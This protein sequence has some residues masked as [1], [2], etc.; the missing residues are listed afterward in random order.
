MNPTI[1]DKP[2]FWLSQLN[3]IPNSSL[4]EDISTEFL[5]IGGG[6]TGL[7]TAY[8]LK[9]LNPNSDITLIEKEYI[10]FGASGRNAGFCMS[11]FGLDLSLTALRYGK[12]NTLSA[13][14]YTKSGIKMVKNFI[15]ENQID[16]DFEYPGF[17]RVAT[18]K[19]YEKR[20]FKEYQF[21]LNI[22]IDD[23]KWLNKEEIKGYIYSPIIRCGW[24]EENCGLLN[25]AKLAIGM[26]NLIEKKGVKIYEKTPFVK[27]K[28]LNNGYEV[29]TEKGSIKTKKIV[30]ATNAY[31]HLI[32]YIKRKQV[33][34]F[35]HIV[36]TEPLT[37]NQI[38][39]IGWLKRQG[40]EDS[41]NLIHYFRLTK[42]NRLLMGGEDVTV[43]FGKKMNYD[44]NPKTFNKLLDFIYKIFPPLK[45]IKI[46]Y[47]WGGPVSITLD[48]IPAIGFIGSKDA[49]FSLGCIGHGV[50]LTHIN[51]LTIAELLLEKET[52]RTNMF[53]INRNI[54]PWPPE[55]IRYIL[56]HTIRSAFKIQDSI[57][58]KISS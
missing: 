40:L 53:F 31:S 55:P 51:G 48:L 38:K 19:L 1:I 50:S 28:K 4:M 22:G 33:P 42:D 6:F 25:P 11:L 27:I 21:A 57:Y 3:I 32:N 41:R 14:Q 18:S 9:K 37:D 43:A 24:L 20:L 30:F 13:Y 39:E 44:L 16:C 56:S 35:T 2:S 52:E 12:A 23:A 45:G 36:L 8:Y 34:A 29:K 7:S 49:I 54:I 5:I 17:I 47:K 15:E 26:K 10:G 58:D 46:E